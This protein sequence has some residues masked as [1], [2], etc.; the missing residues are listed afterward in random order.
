MALDQLHLGIRELGH[1]GCQSDDERTR[2]LAGFGK[3]AFAQS[4]T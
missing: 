4:T 3:P 2:P 1:A